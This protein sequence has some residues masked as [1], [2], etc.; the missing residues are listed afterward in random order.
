MTDKYLTLTRLD[1]VKTIVSLRA[2]AYITPRDDN[3]AGSDVFFSGLDDDFLTV[4][5]TL[6]QI[7]ALL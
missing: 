2:V 7:Q 3:D 5:E 1:G 4:K 6:D